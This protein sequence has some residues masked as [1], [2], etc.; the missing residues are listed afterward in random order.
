M[1]PATLNTGKDIDYETPNNVIEFKENEA[2]DEET[3]GD[4]SLPFGNKTKKLVR[5]EKSSSARTDYKYFTSILIPCIVICLPS[6]YH[7]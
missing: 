1:D 6:K 7:V 3:E 2:Y 5:Q 4:N